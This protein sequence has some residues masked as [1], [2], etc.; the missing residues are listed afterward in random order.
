M[1]EPLLEQNLASLLQH[2]EGSFPPAAACRM[3]RESADIGPLQ[4]VTEGDQHLELVDSDEEESG[5]RCS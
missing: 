2:L 4:A 1:V 5:G 3:Q